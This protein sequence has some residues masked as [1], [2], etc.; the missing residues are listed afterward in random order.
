[1]NLKDIVTL[2]KNHQ[3]QYG[4]NGDSNFN[5]LLILM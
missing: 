3:I 1:M 4:L 2:F 5:T